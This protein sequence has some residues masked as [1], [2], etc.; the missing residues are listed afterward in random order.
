MGVGAGEI[1]RMGAWSEVVSKSDADT[2]SAL[3][4]TSTVKEIREVIMDVSQER[5]GEEVLEV[6]HIS[7][8]SG[9]LW[10]TLSTFQCDRPCKKSATWPTSFSR[11]ASRRASAKGSSTCKCLRMIKSALRWWICPTGTR[12]TTDRR[13][14]C[15]GA[16]LSYRENY[17]RYCST[18]GSGSCDLERDFGA[19]VL[20]GS[21]VD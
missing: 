11:R 1:D 14:T 16:S 19:D 20:Q 12:A 13:A 21:F 10:S 17:G 4:R 3:E 7:G 2:D 15:G 8:C 5:V 9:V 6:V 18:S